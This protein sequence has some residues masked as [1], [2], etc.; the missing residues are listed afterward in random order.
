MKYDDVLVRK[1]AP[2]IITEHSSIALTRSRI[3]A[4]EC[5]IAWDFGG[6]LTALIENGSSARGQ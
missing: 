6:R 2:V 4:S 1:L 5:Y 3:L